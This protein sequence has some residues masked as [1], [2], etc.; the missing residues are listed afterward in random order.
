VGVR[1]GQNS[2]KARRRWVSK[3][4]K[5]N[6]EGVVAL[7]TVKSTG[8]ERLWKNMQDLNVVTEKNSSQK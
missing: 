1:K 7:I 3:R 5:S 6:S 8:W 2:M 4:P